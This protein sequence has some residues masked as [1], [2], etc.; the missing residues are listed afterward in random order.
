MRNETWTKNL[1]CDEEEEGAAESRWRFFLLFLIFNFFS[2]LFLSRWP[3]SVSLAREL[4]LWRWTWARPTI[5]LRVANAYTHTTKSIFACDRCLRPQHDHLEWYEHVLSCVR[6]RAHRI[7]LFTLLCSDFFSSFFFFLFS[8]HFFIA[9]IFFSLSL[10]QSGTHIRV[11]FTGHLR[12]EPLNGHKIADEQRR[13]RRKET[14]EKHKNMTKSTIKRDD[15]RSD[16]PNWNHSNQIRLL[17][18]WRFNR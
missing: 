10:H 4:K 9:I 13:Q 17:T 5:H 14:N 3:K 6:R 8:F 15:V 16:R 18:C 1:R 11:C 12:E 2:Y 7:F